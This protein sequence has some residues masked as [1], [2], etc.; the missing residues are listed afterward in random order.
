M[1][2][3]S[4]G[5]SR[6][7]KKELNKAFQINP[8]LLGICNLPINTAI[9]LYLLIANTMLQTPIYPYRIILHIDLKPATQTY[10]TAYS[11]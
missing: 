5:D 4:A 11:S 9:V 6:A 10:A 1:Q 7:A 8:R 2:L 3:Y